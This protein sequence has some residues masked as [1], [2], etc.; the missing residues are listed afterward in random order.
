MALK[1]GQ[2]QVCIASIGAD[3][4]DYQ[5]ACILC[6]PEGRGI[7]GILLCIAWSAAISLMGHVYAVSKIGS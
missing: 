6:F 5:Q 3:E 4:D 7:S 2:K 1:R